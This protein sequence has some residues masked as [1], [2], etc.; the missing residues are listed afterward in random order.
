[1]QII[2]RPRNSTY[3]AKDK[4]P[5][6][7]IELTQEETEQVIND[8]LASFSTLYDGIGVEDRGAVLKAIT[9][10]VEEENDDGYDSDDSSSSRSLI[11]D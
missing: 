4:I 10:K 5:G 8:F 3:R 11:D 6:A 1:M 7:Q 2:P 9:I